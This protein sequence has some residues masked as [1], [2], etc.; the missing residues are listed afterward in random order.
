MS[1]SDSDHH[2]FDDL[3]S[4]ARTVAFSDVDDELEWFSDGSSHGTIKDFLSRWTCH[5][6]EV[7]PALEGAECLC[8]K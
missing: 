2:E 7:V 4:N 1:G 8:G 3:S 5:I 6:C